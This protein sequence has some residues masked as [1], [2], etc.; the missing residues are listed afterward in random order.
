METNKHA[1][2][3]GKKRW[4]GKTKEERSEYGQMMVAARR[5]KAKEREETGYL[6][7]KR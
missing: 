5:K 2:A 7:D 6:T 4:E 1:R 3:L